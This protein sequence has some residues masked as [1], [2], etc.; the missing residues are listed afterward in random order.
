MAK[1]KK[2]RKIDN[3]PIKPDYKQNL[4]YDVAKEIKPDKIKPVEIFDGFKEKKSKGKKELKKI[5]KKY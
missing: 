3:I 2:T 1:K 4:N 5:K